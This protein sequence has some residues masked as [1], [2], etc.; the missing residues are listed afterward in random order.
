[1]ARPPKAERSRRFDVYLPETLAVR[2]EMLLFSEVENRIPHGEI[3]KFFETLA[4]KALDNPQSHTLS[5]GA[6]NGPVS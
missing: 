3:S 2:I 5:E 4:R 6:P 1:M